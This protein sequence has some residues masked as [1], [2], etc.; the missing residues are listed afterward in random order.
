MEEAQCLHNFAI[1]NLKTTTLA[2]IYI[3]R[4]TSFLNNSKDILPLYQYLQDISLFQEKH[5]FVHL[6]QANVAGKRN[7]KNYSM[8]HVCLYVY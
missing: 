3:L 2:N 6:R 5:Q 8:S 7:Y 4:L 1:S